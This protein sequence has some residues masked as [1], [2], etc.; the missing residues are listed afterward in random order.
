MTELHVCDHC[1]R[2]IRRTESQCPFCSGVVTPSSARPT[3]AS[4]LFAVAAAATVAACYGG[5]Q[6]NMQQPAPQQ[7]PAQPPAQPP[8]VP[9]AT[10]DATSSR[11]QP[12]SIGEARMLADRTLVLELSG[13][14]L[15]D[16]VGAGEFRYP[17]VHPQY[18][19]ILAHIGPIE[20]G[21]RRNVRAF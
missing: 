11:A 19:E 17:T 2:H 9:S 10:P 16:S 12:D 8:A 3:A 1:E 6:R 18:D 5:P 14:D 7:Q 20:P 15:R 21:Q 13:S 4:V